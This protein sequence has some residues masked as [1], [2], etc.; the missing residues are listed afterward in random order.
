MLNSKYDKII[1]E[2]E[3]EQSYCNPSV[4]PVISHHKAKDLLNKILAL[5][6][7]LHCAPVVTIFKTS[8]QIHTAIP[9]NA[10]HVSVAGC[11]VHHS[12]ARLPAC[13]KLGQSMVHRKLKQYDSAR[14]GKA[15]LGLPLTAA[16]IARP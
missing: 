3:R 15:D 8:I 16:H 6:S 14:Q 10:S 13:S 2:L 11:L 7:Q 9:I 4:T 5:N 12:G 1:S